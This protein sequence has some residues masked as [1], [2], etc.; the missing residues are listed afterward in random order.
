MSIAHDIIKITPIMTANL[1]LYY[2]GHRSCLR[3]TTGVCFMEYNFEI[4]KGICILN[5][6]FI[7]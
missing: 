1:G 4:R 6:K 5:F 3:P 7:A 2:L